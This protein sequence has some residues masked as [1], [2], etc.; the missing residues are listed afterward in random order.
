M[1]DKLLQHSPA[2]SADQLKQQQQFKQQQQQQAKRVTSHVRDA[3]RRC[4]YFNGQFI[5]L[6]WLRCFSR[7]SFFRM[8]LPLLNSLLD[9]CCCWLHLHKSLK[10]FVVNVSVIEA[11]LEILHGIHYLDFRHSPSQVDLKSVTGIE[12]WTDCGCS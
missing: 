7:F 3:F 2:N 1:F 9:C 6:F 5:Y 12:L 4:N 8:L 10:G 11:L